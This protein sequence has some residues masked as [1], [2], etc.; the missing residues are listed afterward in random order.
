VQGN[1]QRRPQIDC[2]VAKR[3]QRLL[4]LYAGSGMATDKQHK[5]DA[6]QEGATVFFCLFLGAKHWL[7]FLSLTA[8]ARSMGISGTWM[9]AW[10]ANTPSLTSL[11]KHGHIL[12]VCPFP[13]SKSTVAELHRMHVAQN[14][15]LEGAQFTIR[16]TLCSAAAG[17]VLPHLLYV[18]L[19][20]T[21]R[22]SKLSGTMAP[23]AASAAFLACTLRHSQ[24]TI[25]TTSPFSLVRTRLLPT[26]AC[27]RHSVCE[28]CHCCGPAARLCNPACS[29]LAHTNQALSTAG[30]SRNSP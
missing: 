20:T 22:P 7:T 3:T 18:S 12:L 28:P 30:G 16:C 8:D 17:G 24:H 2:A 29:T 13:L 6:P 14:A 10:G 26:F 25:G 23:A 15:C 11:H 21:S 9:S 5:Q 1:G 27:I 4:W 19:T